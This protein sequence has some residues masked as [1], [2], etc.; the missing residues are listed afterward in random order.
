MDNKHLQK[1][2]MPTLSEFKDASD[3]L[4]Q[5]YGG[6]PYN[7]WRFFRKTDNGCGYLEIVHV[8]GKGFAG[9]FLCR[10]E[11]PFVNVRYEDSFDFCY[12]KLIK[13]SIDWLEDIEKKGLF[14]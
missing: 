14:K 13:Q 8:N 4:A 9:L 3:P 10:N 2:G 6:M 12:E 1:W 7:R 5:T 11:M